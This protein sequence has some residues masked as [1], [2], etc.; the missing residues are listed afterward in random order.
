MQKCRAN[1]EQGQHVIVITI[2]ERVSVAEGLATQEGIG[3]RVDVLDAEQFLA[4]NLHEHGKF[5]Q[6]GRSTSARLLLEKYN[7]I[8]TECETDP[9]LHIRI[10]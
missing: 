4:S 8:V 2:C 1:L 5:L 7:E 9:S 3:D 6:E 10:S